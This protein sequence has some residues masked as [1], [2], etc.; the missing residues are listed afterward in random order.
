MVAECNHCVLKRIKHQARKDGLQVTVLAD[1]KW[2]LDGVN[3]YVHPSGVKIDA[4]RGGEDGARAQ[5]RRAWFMSL[6][7]ACACD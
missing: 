4:L 7:E 6:T 1:A 3:V 5:Y 2:G